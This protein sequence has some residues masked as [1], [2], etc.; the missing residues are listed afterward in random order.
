[1]ELL[2]LKTSLSK[3]KII[4]YKLITILGSIKENLKKPEDIA[5]ESIQI[6]TER[7]RKRIDFCF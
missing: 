3:M 2:E 1:M 4:L 7:G 6:E 5:I